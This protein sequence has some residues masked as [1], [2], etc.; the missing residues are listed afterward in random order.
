MSQE[1][2][3]I[4][5]GLLRRPAIPLLAALTLGLGVSGTIAVGSV[6]RGVLL[7]DLPYP[8]PDRLALVW[9]STP[10]EPALRGP[11]SPPDWLDVRE[12]ARSL[13][14]V[15]GVNSFR[16]TY[17]P[18]E[19]DPEQ[20]D[21]GV[22][23]GE[24][25][26]VL[27]VMPA[28]GRGIRPAD[29]SPADGPDEPAV[30]V[31]DHDFWQRRFGGDPGV[32]GRSV[33]FGG[34][35]HM[36]IGVMPEGFRLLMP[37]DSGM[38]TVL[39]GWTPLA[40]AYASQPRDGFYL[41]VLVRLSPGMSLE[42]ADAELEGIAAALRSEHAVHDDAGYRLR[43]APLPG[44]VVA[45]VRPFLVILG[46][47]GGVVL[48]VTCANV[49]ALLL[50][51]FMGRSGET[52]VRRALGAERPRLIASFLTES[53]LVAGAGTG[54][55][56]L[57]AGPVVRALI[58]LQPGVV[59]R[60][61]QVAVD[62]GLA[63]ASLGLAALITLVCGLGPAMM[64]T[65]GAPAGVLRSRDTGDG[66]VTRRLHGG[67]VV[68]QVAASF[69]LLYGTGLLLS[70]LTRAHRADP[71]Y[72]PEGVLTFTVSL[73]FGQYRGP[74]TWVAFFDALTEG[75]AS[76]P[77]VARTGATSGLPTAIADTPE[78]WAP[79]AAAD[80][81]TWGARR[82]LHMVVTEGYFETLGIDVRAGRALGPADGPDDGLAVV[83]DE[84][85]ANRL[86]RD[87]GE[88][89]GRRLEVT[90]H[91]FQ[92][93]YRIVRVTA[94]VVG[95]VAT[96]PHGHPRADPPGTIYMAQ[97]QYPLW[98]LAVSVRGA[99]G[100]LPPTSVVR[101][102]LAELDPT[103]PAVNVR[104]MSEVAAETLA[105]TVFVL[106]MLGALAGL[107]VAL[108]VAGLYGVISET[109]RQRRRDLGVRLALGASSSEVTRR[110]LIRGILLAGL[111]VAPGLLAIPRVGA[112]LRAALGFGT[113]FDGLALTAAALLVTAVAIAASWL[114]ARRAGRIDPVRVLRSE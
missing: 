67:L 80:T 47:V 42:R 26:D 71:G 24:F 78:P 45:H 76:R 87:G 99:G 86:A 70:D 98:S 8:D 52:A 93:G 41:K 20:I 92:D 19:G 12:R 35:D 81:E 3:P 57:L 17:Q 1:L 50:V 34:T 28:L 101:D 51:R 64:G 107:V 13:E 79:V 82:A 18:G 73:P 7:R 44:E 43:V 111:G 113:T 30:V 14:G 31:L 15:A 72:D 2:L 54:L 10:D 32:V 5:R 6:V 114:P 60:T 77:G 9:R 33:V 95:V 4:L 69:L 21:L 97:P 108:T 100:I 27:G 83:I 36:V 84:T 96:V 23:T 88:V 65:L 62:G 61:D 105:P 112:W 46:L 25:F 29:D 75:L 68:V 39:A 74:S 58:A 102:A 106:A 11:L 59:P 91:E 16:A 94:E 55:G 110:V 89:V 63:L 66:R 104:P 109:V 90:R 56:L 103:V 49:S 37:D 85:L 48:L 53:A 22:V 40:L 38:T